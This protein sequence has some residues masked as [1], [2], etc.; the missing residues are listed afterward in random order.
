MPPAAWT[1]CRT[2]YTQASN[3]AAAAGQK[4][5]V[6]DD[7]YGRAASV[8]NTAAGSAATYAQ[9]QQTVAGKAAGVISA[10]SEISSKFGVSVPAAFCAGGQGG[11]EGR[12]LDQ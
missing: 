3:A 9:G 6:S 2:K 1:T 8:M 12:D 7:A 5:N 10:G 4:V 11:T